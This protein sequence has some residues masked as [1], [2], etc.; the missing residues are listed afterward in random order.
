[1]VH[2]TFLA[3]AAAGS[4]IAAAALLVPNSNKPTT[5]AKADSG[6]GYSISRTVRGRALEGCLEE[7]VHCGLVA[8]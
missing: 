3:L 8:W 5:E 1:M 6:Y 2:K 7:P 4:L